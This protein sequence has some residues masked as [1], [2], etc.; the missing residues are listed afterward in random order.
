MRLQGGC[1]TAWGSRVAYTWSRREGD[2][3]DHLSAGG[4]AIGNIPQNA[5]DDGQADYGPLPFDVPQRL[6]TSFIYELPFGAG[7]RFE[8]A[9]VLGAILRDWSVNGILTLSDGRPF[10]VTARDRAG[11]G[12]GRNVARELRRRP[13]AGRIRSDA[14]R[15]FDARGF[16]P[17]GAFTY[18]NCALQ[19]RARARASSR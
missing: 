9:G 19:H 10:T 13:A 15:W 11:T 3:L 4:G 7:R 18:G 8:P 6:V 5:Y 12:G 14:G 2:F 1:A 17:T 16:A